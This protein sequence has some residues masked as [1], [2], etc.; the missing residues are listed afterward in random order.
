MALNDIV[1]QTNLKNQLRVPILAYQKGLTVG[2]ILLTGPAGNGKTFSAESIADELG[3]AFRRLDCA[4]QGKKELTYIMANM[5]R[6]EFVLNLDEA[7]H[8]GLNGSL[9]GALLD[10]LDPKKRQY[11]VNKRGAPSTFPRMLVIGSTNEPW[12]MPRAIDSR[13]PLLRIRLSTPTDE[14]IA[15]IMRPRFSADVPSK[16]IT[17]LASAAGNNARKA[18][19]IVSH[20]NQL[21]ALDESFTVESVLSDLALSWDGAETAHLEILDF[22]ANNQ[23][24]EFFGYANQDETARAT[25]MHKSELK[26]YIE[27]LERRDYVVINERSQLEITDTG[28]QRINSPTNY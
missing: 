21:I 7:Q 16:L 9:A 28:R 8:I 17:E 18:D 22:L 25:R 26:Y 20:I 4:S 23:K 24:G 10:L 2:N 13:F 11:T 6:S 19:A 12:K 3:I 14:E 1:G 15:E 27:F 5:V